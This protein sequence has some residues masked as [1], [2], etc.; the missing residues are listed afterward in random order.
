[1]APG[2]LFSFNHAIGEITP[3][4]GYVEAAVVDGQ[5]IGRDIG[6]GICQVSTTMFR[7]AYYAGF[8]WEERWPHRYRFPFYELDNVTPGLDASILQPD[9]D[10][11]SGGDFSF[12]NPSQTSWLL[13]EAYVEA[14]RA[15]VIVYGP[16]FGWTVDISAPNYSASSDD[17]PQPPDEEVVDDTLSPGT[18]NP[19]E[20]G[21]HSTD[22]SY[23]RTVT[24]TKGNIVLSDNLYSHY[25]ERPA[26]WAV[27][28]DMQGQSP[29]ASG[30]ITVT[31]P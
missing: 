15:Y 27:S 4:K 3:D 6:G 10:P 29:A 12:R 30:A 20:Y 22:V 31:H 25:Y 17:T 21:L 1:M 16:D 28:P 19:K 24:D 18:V 13:I 26:L 7:A 14:P 9:G 23:D 11:F 2:A 8:S 5:A